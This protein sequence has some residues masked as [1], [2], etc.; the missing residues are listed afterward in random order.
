VYQENKPIGFIQYYL[1]TDFL[2]EGVS[3]ND[4]PVFKQY[5]PSY[6][7]GIDLFIAAERERD[8]GLGVALMHHFI[9]QFLSQNFKAVMVDPH[10]NNRNAIRCYEKADFVNTAFS[11]NSHNLVMI[12]TITKE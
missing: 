2:P 6:L 11:E 4:N 5:Y 9:C 1:L 3:N 10:I 7:A 12:K 8:K